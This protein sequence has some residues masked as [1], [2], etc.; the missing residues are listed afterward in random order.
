MYALLLRLGAGATLATMLMLVKLVSA[1]GV[2]LPHILLFRQAV[3][4]PVLLGF[5]LVRGKWAGCGA[6][7]SCRTVSAR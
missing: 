3:S 6:T 7:G 2:D 1:R 4:V 5:L